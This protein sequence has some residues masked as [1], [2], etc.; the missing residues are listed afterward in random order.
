M[1]TSLTTPGNLTATMQIYYDRVF[2]ERAQAAR[3]Y[4]F[5]AVKKTVPK[6]SG[7]QLCLTLL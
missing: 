3:R 2:L 6:N 1:T 7:K 5:L 4:D